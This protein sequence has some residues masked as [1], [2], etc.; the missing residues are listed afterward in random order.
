MQWADDVT[1]ETPEQID[2]SLELA[3][4]GSR[5]LA[6]LLDWLVKFGSLVLIGIVVAIVLGLLGVAVPS[7]ASFSQIMVMTFWVGLSYLLLVGYDIYFEVRHNGQTPGKKRA[8]I[9]VIRESGAPLDFRSSCIRNLLAIADFVPLFYLLGAFLVLLMSRHQRLGDMAAGT[10]VIRERSP[11]APGDLAPEILKLASD[12]FSFTAE[13]LAP[14]LTDGRFILRSFFQRYHTMQP[15]PRAELAFRLAKEFIARTS[16]QLAEP[17]RSW[18]AAEAFLA[19]LYRDL[20]HLK[21]HG[22]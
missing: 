8:G 15:Q 7:T 21:Q 6:R 1:I 20:E 16:Y 17:L 3:G 10:L 11:E 5:F 19:S 12:E 4:L 2:V 13:Q 9:R 22:R 18:R 14:C